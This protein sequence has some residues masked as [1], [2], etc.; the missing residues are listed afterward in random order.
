[1]KRRW[2]RGLIPASS[3][4]PDAGRTGPSRRGRAAGRDRAHSGLPFLL[5]TR[6]LSRGICHAQAQWPFR[7]AAVRKVA[8]LGWRGGLVRRLIGSSRC[9]VLD[10]FPGPLCLIN[11]LELES[12]TGQ[13]PAERLLAG[14][15]AL[16]CSRHWSVCEGAA[17]M[18]RHGR[19]WPLPD[20]RA[21][22]RVLRAERAGCCGHGG[23]A[24]GPRQH[25]SP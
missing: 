25:C 6:T 23:L 16:L 15:G 7:P 22:G 2:M 4:P 13:P 5:A 24:C 3:R 11:H 14:P 21:L 8:H 12:R 10:R 1:M 17:G 18:D 20:A 9:G 19:R